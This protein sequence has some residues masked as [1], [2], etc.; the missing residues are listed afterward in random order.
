MEWL[1]QKLNKLGIPY[2]NQE[3]DGDYY[4]VRIG[5]K[6]APLRRLDW[7]HLDQLEID[8]I[9][10]DSLPYGWEINVG[11]HPTDPFSYQVAMKA[12]LKDTRKTKNSNKKRLLRHERVLDTH[13]PKPAK[14]ARSFDLF[15]HF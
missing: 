11:P 9:S 13:T 5:G 2:E 1:F 12:R 4:S 6:K 14:G 3:T 8:V 10:S 7:K 15:F